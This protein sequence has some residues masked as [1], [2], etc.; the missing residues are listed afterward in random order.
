MMIA[1]DKPDIMMITEVIPKGQVNPITR[2]LLDIDE[3]ECILN[4]DPNTMNL[5]AS[6]MRGVAIYH[7]K[8]LSVTQVDLPTDEYKDQRVSD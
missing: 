7:K 1:D 6:G 5:G 3:Y 4:F 8:N 2:V